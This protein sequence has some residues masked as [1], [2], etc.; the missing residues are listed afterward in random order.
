M[1]AVI[2]RNVNDLFL[3]V[4]STSG[5]VPSYLTSDTSFTKSAGFSIMLPVLQGL[6]FKI[7]RSKFRAASRRGN[8]DIMKWLHSKDCPWDSRVF[9]ISSRKGNLSIMKWLK[10]NGCPWSEYTFGAAAWYG[11]LENMKWLHENDC[12][13][14]ETTF[15]A[16]LKTHKNYQHYNRRIFVGDIPWRELDDRP[17]TSDIRSRRKEIIEELSNITIKDNIQS[18]YDWR[19]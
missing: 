6:G 17:D 18:S 12:P 7:A 2:S 19:T 8:L 16:A 9:T 10:E 5:S 11:N 15:R 3:L 13:W 14:N 1:E 4:G